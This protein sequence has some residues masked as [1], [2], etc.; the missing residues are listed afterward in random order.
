MNERY[1][2]EKFVSGKPE[3][4]FVYWYSISKYNKLPE[5][6]LTKYTDFGRGRKQ[7]ESSGTIT[8]L[9]APL[10]CSQVYQVGFPDELF[11][12]ITHAST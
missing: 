4:S 2:A 11:K 5:E 6:V 12:A 7:E 10:K 9:L 3:L 1:A 8:P